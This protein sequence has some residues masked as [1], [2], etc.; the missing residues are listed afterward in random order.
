MRAEGRRL[1]FPMPRARE[2][3][4]RSRRFNVRSVW[5]DLHKHIGLD[6]D[7]AAEEAVV[8]GD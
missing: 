8:G 1:F 5:P 2:R 3:S 7:V 4:P 6:M